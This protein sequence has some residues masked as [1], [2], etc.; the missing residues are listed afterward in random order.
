M[1]LQVL[2]LHL[3][4]VKDCRHYKAIIC[5]NTANNNYL[6]SYSNKMIK[7]SNKCKK[8][9]SSFEKYYCHLIK[10]KFNENWTE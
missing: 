7:Q 6:F 2:D 5:R 8:Q 9:I 1:I 10:K 3:L 4:S